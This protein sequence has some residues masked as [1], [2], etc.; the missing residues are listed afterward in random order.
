MNYLSLEK[1]KQII[2]LLVEGNSIRGSARLADVHKNTVLKLLVDVGWACT[3]FLDANLMDLKPKNV[4]VDEIYS[5]VYS[6]P[7]NTPEGKKGAGAV[8]VWVAIDADTK[9]IL[10]WRVGD[11]NGFDGSAFIDDLRRRTTGR[12]QIT[13]DG[14]PKYPDAVEKSFG[15]DVDYGVLEKTY[16]KRRFAGSRKKV[17]TGDP[18]IK[19]INTSFV[20]RQN[21]TMRMDMRRF[22]RKT[23]AFS[24]KFENHC[25]AIALHFMYYNFCRIHSSLRVTPAMEAG[26]AD[27]VWDIIDILALLSPG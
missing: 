14:F 10:T 24:K 5:F 2:H 15:L 23:N 7:K 17:I 1:R 19:K 21:L 9:M 12:F 27:H 26:V 20:E 8:W 11:R 22:H 25:H 13:S 6:H 16:V 3:D 18:D 4:Q